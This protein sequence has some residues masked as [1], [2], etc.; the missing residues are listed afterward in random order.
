MEHPTHRSRLSNASPYF[1]RVAS[2]YLLKG[3]LSTVL[4]AMVNAVFSLI[5]MMFRCLAVADLACNG[6]YVNDGGM[7]G[8]LGPG[9]LVKLQ[10]LGCELKREIVVTRDSFLSKCCILHQPD[11]ELLHNSSAWFCV[12]AGV[13][14][15]KRN[16]GR[17]FYFLQ[18][19]CHS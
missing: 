2:S 15:G 11:I 17:F 16:E 3:L 8:L 7:L 4:N 12:P 9:W 14:W 1:F 19:G 6:R 18:M 10:H 13:P 5:V